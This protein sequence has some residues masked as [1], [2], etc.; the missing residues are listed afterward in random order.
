MRC[1][2]QFAD[3]NQN[4]VE[5]KLL[6]I[7]G[8]EDFEV[9]IKVSFMFLRTYVNTMLKYKQYEKYPLSISKV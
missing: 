5:R 4:N 8:A 2:A 3:R 9:K 7:R 1:S 6:D